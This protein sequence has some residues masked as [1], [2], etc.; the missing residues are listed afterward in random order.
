LSATLGVG[1]WSLDP[2]S[3]TIIDR[4]LSDTITDPIG[5][6]FM[7]P[8]QRPGQSEAKEMST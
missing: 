6:E 7:A 1:G 4:I 8:P 3:K 2:A 5:P